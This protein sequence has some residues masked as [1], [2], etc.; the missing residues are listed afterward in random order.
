MIPKTI[1]LC[2]FSGDAYPVEIKLCLESWKRLMPDYTVRV[3]T[4]EDARAIGIQYINEALDEHRWA[5][6]SDA[7]RFYALWS[8]GGV[9]MDSDILL[10]RRF[11]HLLPENGECV[12][13]NECVAE[14][15]TDFGLQAAFIIAD[16]GN[17]FCRRM[18]D[19]YSSRPYRRPDGSLDNTISPL[20]M[21]EIATELGYV[22]G[23][24]TQQRLP[25]LTVY[26]TRML[27]PRKRYATD[28]DT[29]GQHRVYGSWRKRKMSRRLEKSIE[30]FVN[31][32]RYHLMS[33]H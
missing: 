6:A 1:H 26:P 11:D 2:W 7:V 30:H 15:E 13:F 32:V 29:I 20:T 12:T 21:R 24:D 27:A 19:Y 28:S 14:G 9:Y 22:P 10:F 4:A 8:E 18:V 33:R 23:A 31:V 16:K 5:F 25:G 3:W 17:D